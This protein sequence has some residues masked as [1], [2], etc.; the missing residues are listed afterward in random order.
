MGQDLTDHECDDAASGQAQDRSPPRAP[1]DRSWRWLAMLRLVVVM[2]GVSGDVSEVVAA[3]DVVRVGRVSVLLGFCWL[4]NVLVY[5][6]RDLLAAG[7][8]RSS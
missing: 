7:L 3:T 6:H 1:I 5:G 8:G 4:A 2:L